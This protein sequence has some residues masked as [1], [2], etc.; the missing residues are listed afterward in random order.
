MGIFSEEDGEL[1][2]S[3]LIKKCCYMK[4]LF[5]FFDLEEGER[6]ERL[7]SKWINSVYKEI[8]EEGMCSSE[9]NVIFFSL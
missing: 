1:L 6:K 8:C 2:F 5:L 7:L 4:R 3:L 9:L